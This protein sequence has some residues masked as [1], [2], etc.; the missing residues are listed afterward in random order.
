[1]TRRRYATIFVSLV[2]LFC[3]TQAWA[4]PLDETRI[5]GDPL[6]TSSGAIKRRADVLTAFQKAHPCPSTGLSTG[7]CAGWA[8]DHIIP[9]VKGGC[10][11]V[12]NLQ[13]LPNV[14][15]SGRGIYPKDRWEQRV[16]GISP[17]IVIMPESGVLSVQ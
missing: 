9:L 1:M 16:Y 15:K 5:C 4:G 17:Q 12:S 2:T 10:D 13:W 8:R 6:R 11:A 3:A 14:L 7:A